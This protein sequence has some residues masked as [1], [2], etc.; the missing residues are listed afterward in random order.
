MG[1]FIADAPVFVL[2]LHGLSQAREVHRLQ[3]AQNKAN[4][5]QMLFL[6]SRMSATRR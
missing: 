5:T 2:F 3:G 4:D 1:R 6:E